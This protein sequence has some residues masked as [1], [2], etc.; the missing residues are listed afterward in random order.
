MIVCR[1]FISDR[2]EMNLLFQAFFLYLFQKT[3]SKSQYIFLDRVHLQMQ[4]KTI[5]LLEECLLLKNTHVS[6]TGLYTDNPL[7]TDTRYNDKIRYNDNLTVT[8]TS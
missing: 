7:Y 1:V 4:A 5:R 3:I 8:G 2:A 6:F